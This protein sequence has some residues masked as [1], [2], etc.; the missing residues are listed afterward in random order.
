[1][2]HLERGMGEDYLKL[3]PI[4][5]WMTM[6][7]FT[8]D[9]ARFA[10]METAKSA[11]FGKS[12]KREYDTI[13]MIPEPE[14]AVLSLRD[15]VAGG[16]KGATVTKRICQR[17]YGTAVARPFQPGQEIK[18]SRVYFDPLTDSYRRGGWM[19]WS[20]KKGDELRLGDTRSLTFQ[21]SYEEGDPLEFHLHIYSCSLED[22][23]QRDDDPDTQFISDNIGH[24]AR[25][26][27]VSSTLA[28]MLSQIKQR[29]F[30]A[31]P[32]ISML[33]KYTTIFLVDDSYSMRDIPQYGLMPWTETTRALAECADIVPSANG[34]LKIHFFSSETSENNISSVDELR[35]LC[36]AVVP[37]GYTT[38]Y[39]LLQRQLNGFVEAFRPLTVA[40][41]EEYPGL[42]IIVFTA[43]AP[44]MQFYALEEVIVGNAQHL[45]VFSP[46]FDRSKVGIHFIQIGDYAGFKA[47]VDRVD[48]VNGIRNLRW[49]I[50]NTTRYN[51]RTVTE[52]TYRKTVLGA[53]EKGRNH[54][55]SVDELP[56]SQD[57]NNRL[58][59]QGR[60][61][62]GSAS[63][64]PD[65]Y[66]GTLDEDRLNEVVSIN[67]EVLENRM[68]NLGEG[69]PD[70]ISAMNNLA[71][72][73][74]NQGR[75]NEAEVMY[76]RAL[77]SCEKNPDHIST[78]NIINNLASFKLEAAETMYQRAFTG[79]EEAYGRD[80][81]STLNTINNLG[82][83]RSD[84][85]SLQE[86]EAMYSRASG[87]Y[88][89]VL[90]LNHTSTLCA[91][92][93]LGL[94]YNHQGKLKEAE[95]M[96]QRAL[97]GYETIQGLY[98]P[99][100]LNIINNLGILHKNQ[101]KLEEAEILY[102]QALKGYEKGLGSNHISMLGTVNNLGLLYTDQGKLEEA[103]VMYHPALKGYDKALGPAHTST[104]NTVNNLG[105]L[106]SDQGRL[107]GAESLYRRAL[108]GYNKALGP[109]HTSTLS[110]FN[111]MGNLDSDQGRL[112]VAESLRRRALKGCNKALGPDHT[113]MLSAGRLEEAVPLYGRAL[114]GYE[115]VLGPDHTSTLSAVNNLGNW[116]SDQGRLKEAKIFY[117]R[118]LEGYE[119]TLSAD[120]ENSNKSVAAFPDLDLDFRSISQDVFSEIA[121]YSSEDYVNGIDKTDQFISRTVHENFHK[122]STTDSINRV[123]LDINWELPAFMRQECPDG[124]PVLHIQLTSEVQ[125]A[126]LGAVV[127]WNGSEDLSTGLFHANLQLSGTTQI[128][129]D[130]ILAL[131]WLA[132]AMW[133]SP[134]EETSFLMV[135]FEKTEPD[136]H[137]A[138]RISLQALTL[139]TSLRLDSKLPRDDVELDWKYPLELMIGLTENT[140]PLGYAGNLFLIGTHSALIP[141]AILDGHSLQWHLLISLK[142]ISL[143]DLPKTSAL[144]FPA[145]CSNEFDIKG[146]FQS[147]RSKRHFLGWCRNARIYLGV[148]PEM[149]GK[150]ATIAF[151]KTSEKSKEIKFTSFN[152][153]IASGGLGFG[154]PSV[155]VTFT[156]YSTRKHFSDTPE[157]RFESMLS[158]AQRM[159]SILYSPEERRA[160]MVPAICILH[161]MA[162]LRISRDR[163]EVRLPYAIASW[164]GATAAYEAVDHNRQIPIGP[165]DVAKPYLLSDMLV[166]L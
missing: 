25:P 41:G 16:L 101:D 72:T 122:P 26:D 24:D 144:S 111:N 102:Q 35:K 47:F 66:A 145:T 136:T 133:T 20:V 84:Q 130:C 55:T 92:N 56:S 39:L 53:I 51:P 2:Q 157:Q 135:S 134:A 97:I 17:R 103:E 109:D 74:E 161:H 98:H 69:H 9:K 91:I 117:P 116:Y 36:S 6:P 10:M 75:L 12:S 32:A 106:Y 110:A 43:G 94:L 27:M 104:L 76:L 70:T 132:A 88:E 113:S 64:S 7:V 131:A 59:Q 129:V 37:R 4:E 80:Y 68:K 42:N 127:D 154:G 128:L 121:R 112:K 147:L 139:N 141:T 108:I 162:L 82:N 29:N 13:N 155:G 73:L 89:K 79:Y 143:Q 81:I 3:T 166:E 99:S 5:F 83:L 22:P 163:Y 49:E 150:S 160:W 96:Y 158:A 125:L 62:T 28:D 142:E 152:A 115:K 46:R 67:K 57:S 33:R 118:L 93:N 151:T 60:S 156:M 14:A 149:G 52:T 86:A 85:G 45:D 119:T 114:Q 54:K 107:E 140:M 48:M 105:N 63:A 58:S 159:P 77:T 138:F 100:T 8:S 1:M 95:A 15:S 78:L 44:E 11:G 87:G 38:I 23:P 19:N 153:G 40:Q 31:R 124:Q 18:Y 71:S 165:Q 30:T 50:I 90:S 34:R 164:D 137:I 146:F 120:H 123:F 61:D 65:H 148:R 21:R 126:G